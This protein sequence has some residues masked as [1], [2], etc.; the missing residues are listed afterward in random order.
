MKR[1]L[2]LLA[3]SIGLLAAGSC[4]TA[5][6]TGGEAPSARISGVYRLYPERIAPLPAPEGYLPCYI[7]H[8]GRHGSRYLLRDDEYARVDTLLAAAAAAG[9]LTPAGERIFREWQAIRPQFEGR[10][11]M[12]TPIG[13]AQH[14][15]IARRMVERNSALFRGEVS[16]RAATSATAR[17]R[18]SM[19][20]FCGELRDRCPSVRIACSENP[21]LNPYSA[22]S[23]I[24]TAE[25]LR[26]KSADA[27]WCPEFEAFCR[28]KIDAERFAAR[29]F[30]DTDCAAECGDPVAFERDLFRLAVHF[31]G[32]GIDLDWLRLFTADE[33]RILAQCEA[34]TFYL[35]K[36]PS[37][38]T[39]DR[40]WALSVHL[41]DRI[42]ADAEEALAEG[43]AADLRFGHD[44][45]IMALLTLMQAE[46]WTAEVR[47]MDRAARAWDVSQ[48]PMACNLQ[49]IFYRPASGGGEL[50]VRTL[51]DERPLRLPVTDAEGLCTWRALKSHFEKRCA[52]ARAALEDSAPRL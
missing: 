9:R 31:A 25:D 38:E 3:V 42:L 6:R 24:P 50:L 15:A 44:G 11:G 4:R 49:W 5:E 22:E 48:I 43:V 17:T 33:R 8:Y 14:R 20:A 40:T 34:C 39:S 47:T 32:C 2:L 1:T 7:S 12:L 16:V 30:T 13:A 37:P 26:V 27:G 51:L 36:G 41:L 28:R 45:C 29:I 35:E 23:G 19:A 21:A 10:A 52:A 18:E 46:G